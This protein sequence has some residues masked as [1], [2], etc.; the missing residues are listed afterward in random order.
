[1]SLKRSL[2]LAAT[3][4]VMLG[5]LPLSAQACNAEPYIGTV[6]TFAFDWCPQGY[7]P[8]DGRLLQIREYTAL[9]GLV[10]FRYGGDQQNTFGIPDLRGRTPVGKGLGTG[11]T[12][13]I[14]MGQVIGQQELT[15]APAQLP[16]HTHTAVF[17]PTTGSASVSIPASAGNLTVAAA[18]QVSPALGT[19]TG[20]TA[21][22]GAG[23]TGYLAGLKGVTSSDAVNFTG[24]YT[25]AVPGA[26][27]A[28]LPAKVTVTGSAP[29][30]AAT[31]SVQ[32]LTGGVVAISPTPAPTQAVSTQSPGIG[33]SVCI[34]ATGLYPNRP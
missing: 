31:V 3:A 7:L 6:C 14:A 33:M 21:A 25:G 5:A 15:L 22:L 13:S 18:L 23:Q 12:Q 27:A 17:T 2:R 30:A 24:P 11:L 20:T 1:M 26:N 10:G 16:A 8:A 4:A 29:T 9:F 28:Q 32:T 34:A 19:V